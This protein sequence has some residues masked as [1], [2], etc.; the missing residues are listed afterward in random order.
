MKILEF[1]QDRMRELDEEDYDKINYMI[2]EMKRNT[3]IEILGYEMQ[4]DGEKVYAVQGEDMIEVGSIS[5]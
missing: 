3:L 5:E 4:T 2:D 1:N